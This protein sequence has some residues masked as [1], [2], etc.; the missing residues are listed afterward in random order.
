[1]LVVGVGPRRG[2]SVAGLHLQRV[3]PLLLS[4]E[5][6][7]REDFPSLH[8][9]LEEVLAFVPRRIHYVV[10]H[11]ERTGD[12]FIKSD[13]C[14]AYLNISGSFVYFRK[15]NWGTFHKICSYKQI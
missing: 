11:L 10:V 13:T 9:D 7:L 2:C 15:Q 4:V 1:M 3:R 14:S 6:H 8:A 12:L 5:H